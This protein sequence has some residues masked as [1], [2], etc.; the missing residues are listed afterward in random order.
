MT[1]LPS[2]L[3]GPLALAILLA[4]CSTGP[5]PAVDTAALETEARYITQRFV[6]T[7]LPTL[8]QALQNGGPVN[9][10]EVC[11]V[12][13]PL[14]AQSLSEQSGWSVRRV[15]LKTRNTANA[16][17]DAFERQ[18]L[19]SF[20]SRQTAGEAGATLSHGEVRSGEYRFMQAQ[21]AMPLCLTCHGDNL[22]PEVSSALARLYPG[23]SATGYQQGQIRGAIS[24]RRALD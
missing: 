16:T 2:R 12:Q 17:P 22:A 11:A 15:S 23:D 4:G 20:D 1:L 5:D 8:Q 13:A 19:R 21:P 3:A 10:I 18:I 7:L 6:G 9:A 24:L 14:I